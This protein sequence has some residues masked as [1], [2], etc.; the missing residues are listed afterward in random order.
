MNRAKLVTTLATASLLVLGA[1]P[2]YAE[3][4]EGEYFGTLRDT[5]NASDWQVKRLGGTSS[6]GYDW[7]TPLADL[8]IPYQD[9]YL[10]STTWG[11][12][13]PWMGA[14]SSGT[15][16]PGY[17]SFKTTFTD[18][19]SLIASGQSVEFKELNVV[20]NVDDYVHAVIINGI[21][22]DGIMSP[23][24][25]VA[26]NYPQYEISN[27]AWNV[28]GLNTIEFIVRDVGGYTGISASMQATYTITAIPEPETWTMLLAGLG[29][30]G[31][32]ARRRRA[33][34]N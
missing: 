13:A 23:V 16:G 31:A 22:Y 9:A 7:K 2:A 28:G 1:M 27:I 5:S 18:D 14:S 19:F 17:Y 24:P 3:L 4:P 32:V 25:G 6:D 29:V 21:Q 10:F 8:A 12:P 34:V 26:S 11:G 20:F 30:V 15:T 33:V